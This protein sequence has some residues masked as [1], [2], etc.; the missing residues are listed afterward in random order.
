MLYGRGRDKIRMAYPYR[1]P[2]SPCMCQQPLKLGL[3]IFFVRVIIQKYIPATR[4]Y[5]KV[6]CCFIGGGTACCQ[7]VY[8][9]KV[10]ILDNM[11]RFI[12][13]IS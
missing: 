10:M 6:L 9:K 13:L 1:M 5:I 12:H 11:Q 2:E 8:K 7:A 4:R 3:N